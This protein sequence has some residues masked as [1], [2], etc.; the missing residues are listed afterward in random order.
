MAIVI[1]GLGQLGSDVARL[2]QARGEDVVGIRRTAPRP[3]PLP[4]AASI[5]S[6]PTLPEPSP[7]PERSP[8]PEPVEGRLTLQL[9]DIASAVPT[10]PSDTSAVVVALAPR[11]RSVAAYD[12]LYRTGIANILTAATR[13]RGPGPRIVFVSSTAVWGEDA[14]DVLDDTAPASP[15]TGTAEALLSAERAVLAAV[16]DACCVRFGG[17]YGQASTMLVDQVRA[18]RVTRPSGWT[19]RIH[20]DDAA[21]VI[22]HLLD[23]PTGSLPPVVAGIDREPALLSD[24]VDHLAAALGV[25]PPTLDE[26]GRTPDE[27]RRGKRIIAAALAATGFEYRYPTFREGYAALLPTRPEFRERQPETADTPV[28]QAGIGHNAVQRVRFPEF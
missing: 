3:A 7:L 11:E 17:L 28:R 10:L 22:T 16:S 1:V 2:L 25:G 14:G 6:P 19:N 13:L 20:R 8:L 5:P 18:G 24:V 4:E 27:R 26:A 12:A 23:L 15:L 9:L 21:A